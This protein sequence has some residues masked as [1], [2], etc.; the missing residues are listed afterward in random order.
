MNTEILDGFSP[1]SVLVLTG[2]QLVQQALR[3]SRTRSLEYQEIEL[4]HAVD[5]L[6]SHGSSEHMMF[7][8]SRLSRSSW[9]KLDGVSVLRTDSFQIFLLNDS[10]IPSSLI[11]KI[12]RSSYIRLAF[13]ASQTTRI[14]ISQF[15]LGSDSVLSELLHAVSHRF[16]FLPVHTRRA[17]IPDP[18]TSWSALGYPRSRRTFERDIEAS[19]I[20]GVCTLRR[21]LKLA[22]AFEI[23]PAFG[24]LDDIAQLS[25]FPSERALADASAQFLKCSLRKASVQFSSRHIAS[26]LSGELLD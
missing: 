14:R 19:G 25:G 15:L 11:L 3:S 20:R 8:A 1:S 21:A 4:A 9:L 2:D 18:A 13:P 16:L 23:A 5:R 6:M 7:S 12:A 22:L 10:G 26:L 24:R 17:I